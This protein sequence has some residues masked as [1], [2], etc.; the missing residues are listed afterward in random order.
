MTG[1]A[2]I[3]DLG[4]VVV[5]WEPARAPAHLFDT[6]ADALARLDAIGFA[7]WNLEQDRG[8]SREDGLA[9]MQRNSP[10]I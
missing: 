3:F 6:E 2:V 10:K 4:Q 9:L 7:A 5:K 1:K 8:R